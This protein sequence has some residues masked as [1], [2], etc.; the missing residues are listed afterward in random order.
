MRSIAPFAGFGLRI[1]GNATLVTVEHREIQAVD[2]R[3][4]AQLVARGIS[5]TRSLNLDY[6]GSKP[7]QNLR[8]GRSGLHMRHIQN[9]DAFQGFPHF[10]LVVE[11]LK[12]IVSGEN[13]N[14][15]SNV[16]ETSARRRRTRP[17]ADYRL[18][19]LEKRVTKA[20]QR[21]AKC[22]GALRSVHRLKLPKLGSPD[23]V[24]SSGPITVRLLRRRCTF[25]RIYCAPAEATP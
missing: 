22:G 2:S 11:I 4:V 5:F 20:G 12:Q 18:F 23:S 16:R 1:Q 9:P 6:V 17:P 3:N 10:F 19:R 24:V 7:C 14:L 8:A 21:L 13:S 15:R 25:L